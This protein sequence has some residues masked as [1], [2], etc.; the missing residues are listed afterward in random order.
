MR[1]KREQKR[2]YFDFADHVAPVA[3]KFYNLH[4][5]VV[6]PSKRQ[7]MD[8]YFE[9]RVKERNQKLLAIDKA[10]RQ[11]H[12]ELFTKLTPEEKQTLNSIED[13]LA[14]PVLKGVALEDANNGERLDTARSNENL[15][16]RMPLPMTELLD[17]PI[18]TDDL[19]SARSDKSLTAEQ[20][21][22]LEFENKLQKRRDKLSQKKEMARLMYQNAIDRKQRAQVLDKH[23]SDLAQYLPPW[24]T[25]HNITNEQ[26]V[27]HLNARSF[28]MTEIDQKNNSKANTKN[29]NT[30]ESTMTLEQA[31][32]IE[33]AQMQQVEEM[34][35][36]QL[37]QQHANPYL[38]S[39]PFV[40]TSH[41]H[42]HKFSTHLP[43]KTILA[44]QS[45]ILHKAG[46]SDTT[47]ELYIRGPSPSRNVRPRR[48]SL[49][50]LP[51]FIPASTTEKP[52][53]S[54]NKP[55]SNSSPSTTRK[56]KS[57]RLILITRR[58]PSTAHPTQ[59][60]WQ[61]GSANVHEFLGYVHNHT[62]HSKAHVSPTKLANTEVLLPLLGKQ[63]A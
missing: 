60:G 37:Q 41:N 30:V 49:D 61:F 59:L 50:Q 17:Q 63:T 56:K 45:K 9:N 48:T 31:E 46:L 33:K 6:S 14:L 22:K 4:P 26:D 3:P 10:K 1:S 27:E 20:V 54:S 35:K 44:S 23:D 8:Q 12:K 55:A 39:P 13:F 2:Q 19:P 18:H 34:Q 47:P 21:K 57:N 62:H 58:I 25:E 51:M 28:F 43:S 36:Q 38:S 15:K 24:M 32:K 42:Y 5:R 7:V 40:N 53:S 29:T 16:M 52:S 11:A